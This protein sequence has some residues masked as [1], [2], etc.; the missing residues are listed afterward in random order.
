MDEGV[1]RICANCGRPLKPDLRKTRRCCSIRCAKML[2]LS[3]SPW[4]NGNGFC[5]HKDPELAKHPLVRKEG[6]R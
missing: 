4:R 3:K 1:K 5:F 2:A 6:A